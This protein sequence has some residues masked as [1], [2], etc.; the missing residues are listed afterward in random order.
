MASMLR[1]PADCKVNLGTPARMARSEM[2]G[3]AFALKAG[4]AKM[5]KV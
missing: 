4:L 1:Q 5:L 3:D 2:D